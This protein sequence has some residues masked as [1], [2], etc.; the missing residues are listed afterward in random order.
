MSFYGSHDDFSLVY[1]NSFSYPYSY[2]HFDFHCQFLSFAFF[3]LHTVSRDTAFKRAAASPTLWL[4]VTSNG[5][6]S[7]S[8]RADC[9]SFDPLT[10]PNP[11]YIASRTRLRW[12]SPHGDSHITTRLASLY[13][14]STSPAMRDKS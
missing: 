3:F 2:S 7:T 12:T 4:K 1:S 6:L 8:S 9:L 13:S 11:S 5:H 10:V 14:T